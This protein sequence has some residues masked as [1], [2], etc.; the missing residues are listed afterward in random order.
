M[1]SVE[2]N[3]NQALNERN[4][5]QD[6]LNVTKEESREQLKTLSEKLEDTEMQR[7]ALKGSRCKESEDLQNKFEE[8]VIQLQAAI[9]SKE[10]QICTLEE[11]LRQQTEE[12][13]NLCISLDQ[14]AAQVNA[15]T[16]HVKALTHEKE[17]HSQSISEKVQRIEELSAENRTISESLKTNESLI[18]DLESIISDLKNQ[19]ASSIKE[20]EEAINQLNRQYKEETQHAAETI[21]RLEQ[22]KRPGLEELEREISEKNEALQRLTASINNQS[23]SKSEMDQVLSEKEQ[24]VSGLTSELE[25]CISR[26]GELQEQLALKTQECEQL[27]ADLKQQHSIRE[28][29]K[30]ELVEQLQQTQMQCAQ[31]WEFGAGVGRKTT[32][33]RGRQPKVSNQP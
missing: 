28:N 11:N 1:E 10:E 25:S 7:K 30:K 17:N 16:E 4:S 8:N 9:Q 3:L 29:E 31:N 6:Q 32:L 23:I 13:K 15:H 14:M 26:L 24:T 19:L 33:P 5:L 21:E 20:K 22:E 2:R 12:N 27:T 18:G